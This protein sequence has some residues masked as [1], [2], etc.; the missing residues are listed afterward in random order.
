MHGPSIPLFGKK[1]FLFYYLLFLLCYHLLWFL[2]YIICELC[3]LWKAVFVGIQYSNTTFQFVHIQP[4]QLVR[5]MYPFISWCNNILQRFN[6]FKC[7]APFFLYSP[8]LL[9]TLSS[10]W[11]HTWYI[12]WSRCRITRKINWNKYWWKPWGPVASWF[13][14]IYRLNLCW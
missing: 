9:F 4:S 7:C 6:L 12:W 13:N 3:L 8:N 2:F 10:V 5:L 11:I 1:I 14:W